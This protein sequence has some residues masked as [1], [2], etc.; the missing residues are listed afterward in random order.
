MDTLE[1]ISKQGILLDFSYYPKYR[2]C[3][4]FND[5]KIVNNPFAFN[6]LYEIPTTRYR[7]Y[8]FI[9]L[10]NKFVKLDLNVCNKAKIQ[11]ILNIYFENAKYP[12]VLSAHS[13]SLFSG[14]P[15]NGLKRFKKK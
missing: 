10:R 1:I 8:K 12:I 7:T 13:F 15:F 4:I 6:K 14:N 9:R 11:K 2:R 3:R 5:Y